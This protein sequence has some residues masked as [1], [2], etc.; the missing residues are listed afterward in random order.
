MSKRS[1]LQ[2]EIKSLDEEIVILEV[3]RSRSMAAIIDALV[4][5]SDPSDRDIEFF[6]TYS[7]EIEVKRE[8]LQALT[9]QMKNL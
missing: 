8:Q 6:R 1:S 3:K 5:K 9:T 7:A 2:K 4:K